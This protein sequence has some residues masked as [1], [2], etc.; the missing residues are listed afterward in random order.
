M[1]LGNS[2]GELYH[3]LSN[4]RVCFEKLK[5]KVE[6]HYEDEPIRKKL[7]HQIKAENNP[8]SFVQEWAPTVPIFC[9]SEKF[10]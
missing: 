6:S 9:E 2:S 7:K 1:Y 3:F 8:R 5:N 10:F 4:L